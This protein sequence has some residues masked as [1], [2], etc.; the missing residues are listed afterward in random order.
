LGG[1]TGPAILQ[2]A[3]AAEKICAIMITEPGQVACGGIFESVFET[4]FELIDEVEL[5]VFCCVALAQTKTWL[6]EIDESEAKALDE[7]G[8]HA[9][10]ANCA[11]RDENNNSTVKRVGLNFTA[12]K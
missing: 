9:A 3:S 1:K 8:A 11:F 6:F 10:C 5:V 2:P 12:Q 4:V 7:T